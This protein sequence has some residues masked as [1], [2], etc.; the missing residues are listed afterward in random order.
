[1]VVM[2][3]GLH[4]EMAAF[5]TI[6]DWLEDSGWMSALVEADITSPG[7]ADSFLKHPTWRECS[8]GYSWQ[9]VHLH[10]HMVWQIQRGFD[11]KWSTRAFDIWRNRCIQERP[12]FQYWSTTLDFEL[13][14]LSFVRSLREANFQLYID[15]LLPWFVTLDHT[16]YSRWLPVHVRDMRNLSTSSCSRRRIWE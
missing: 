13:T 7:T 12:Q 16:P 11:C 2:F 6:G 3:G 14:I 8:S 4:I 1:M 5:R 10:E 15:S 9:F